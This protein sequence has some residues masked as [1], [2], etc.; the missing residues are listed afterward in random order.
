MKYYEKEKL[1]L[2]SAQHSACRSLDPRTY[3]VSAG[4]RHNSGRSILGMR[5]RGYHRSKGGFGSAK[6]QMKRTCHI[7]INQSRPAY[8]FLY[9]SSVG[10]VL[11]L[12]RLEHVF[13]ICF[14]DDTTC[15]TTAACQI[16]FSN[17]KRQYTPFMK[18]QKFSY[19][20]GTTLKLENAD[21]NTTRTTSSS[22]FFAC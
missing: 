3:Q 6:H 14:S 19:R 21:P 9:P 4:R 12:R 16:W 7:G 1:Q 2:F 8:L 15:R 22:S 5:A 20:S 18:D 17:F 10:L 13:T 11:Y